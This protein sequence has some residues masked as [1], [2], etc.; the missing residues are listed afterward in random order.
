MCVCLRGNSQPEVLNIVMDAYKRPKKII[1][2][3]RFISS[4]C[5]VSLHA[6]SIVGHSRMVAAS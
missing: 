3:P 4:W 1:Q 6:I 2:I 5:C